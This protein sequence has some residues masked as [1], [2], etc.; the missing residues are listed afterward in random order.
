MKQAHRQAGFSLMELL[1]ATAIGTFVM[2]AAVVAATD[3][4]RLLG[5]TRS[6]MVLQDSGRI[7]LDLLASDLRMAG[8][9]VGYR[10][11]GSFAG[12]AR[13]AFTVAGGASFSTDNRSLTLSQGTVTTDDLGIRRGLGDVRTIASYTDGLAQVCAGSG[14][15]A[16]NVMVLRSRTGASARTIRVSSV[17][18]ATC[19][20]AS[21]LGGCEDITFSGD[22]TYASDP[23]AAVADYTSG[24]AALGFAEIVWFVAPGDDQ[25][26]ELRRAEVTQATPC[27]AADASCGGTVAP[28]VQTLQIAVWQWDEPTAS[29]VDVTADAEV[30]GS[31]RI[32]VDAEIVIRGRYV[33]VRAPHRESVGLE[34]KPDECVPGPCGAA[35]DQIERRVLR[36]SVELRNS[37]RMNLN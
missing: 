29:W 7:S 28:A 10:P 34:L 23:Y 4:T 12:L 2:L 18:A 16:G 8:Y 5:K 24:E 36:T 3:H 22:A 35:V 25:W 17:S 30:S 9:A 31:R 11:D 21:C 1:V 37:G 20:G 32:R 6:Q 27:T 19:Q 33:D 26:G 13:G 15:A 14:A